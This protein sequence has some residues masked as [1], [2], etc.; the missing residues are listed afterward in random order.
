MQP[1]AA[2][3]RV[4]SS[5]VGIMNITQARPTIS[6]MRTA[7]AMP[8]SVSKAA[9]SPPNDRQI[10]TAR[11]SEAMTRSWPTA[12]A[13][14]ATS[15]DITSRCRL[16]CDHARVQTNAVV[17]ITPP[18]VM[19]ARYDSILKSQR[20]EDGVDHGSANPT[21]PLSVAS[22]ADCE[23]GMVD[24]GVV[25]GV[26]PATVV[27][28]TVS[29]VVIGAAATTKLTRPVI[30]CPSG[31]TR[32]QRVLTSPGSSA[33]SGVTTSVSPAAPC[34]EP[35]SV[36]LTPEASMSSIESVS[37]GTDLSN[38]RVIWVGAADGDPPSAG[39]LDSS[40]LCADAGLAATRT[41][42]VNAMKKRTIRRSM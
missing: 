28:L 13:T 1:P 5:R 33:G 38:T 19:I 30:G 39:S 10:G 14:A 34:V 37:S 42:D 12:S 32:R 26:A 23:T 7:S 9:A 36:V 27:S 41:T 4:D 22:A 31:P 3:H 17:A 6:A 18:M 40:V 11:M 15:E 29:I 25:A 20:A 21:L 35:V 16:G 8:A 2:A 24:D